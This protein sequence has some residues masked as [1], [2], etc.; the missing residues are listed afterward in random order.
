VKQRYFTR[1]AVIG[2]RE[3]TDPEFGS[4]SRF[5]RL[6]TVPCTRIGTVRAPAESEMAPVGG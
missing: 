3:R 1:L 5:V 6:N 4:P 2:V